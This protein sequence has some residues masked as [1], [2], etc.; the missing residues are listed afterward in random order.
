M[1]QIEAGPLPIISQKWGQE[2]EDEKSYYISPFPKRCNKWVKYQ[3]ELFKKH[4]PINAC[5]IE[6]KITPYN[7]RICFNQQNLTGY[8]GVPLLISFIEKMGMEKD[9]EEDQNEHK[10]LTKRKS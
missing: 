10:A 4:N 6:G 7:S 5:D 2:N 8:G 3:T 9:L 1:K